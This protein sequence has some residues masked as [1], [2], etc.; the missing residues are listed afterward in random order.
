MGYEPFSGSLAPDHSGDGNGSNEREIAASA[1]FLNFGSGDAGNSGGSGGDVDSHGTRF[2]DTI[3]A[4][5]DKLNA[6]GSFR[7]RRGRKSGGSTNSGNSRAKNHAGIEALTQ[8]LAIV[9]LGIAS[10]TKTPEF[11]LE[12]TEAETLAKAVSNVLIEFDI[13][14]DPKAQAIFGLVVAAGSVYGPRVYLIRERRKE[15]RKSK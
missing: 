3:H 11:V 14:P 7:K 15:E 10:A 9:H 1:S 6:D 8:A 13:Q 2:D 4:G 12:D 5:R